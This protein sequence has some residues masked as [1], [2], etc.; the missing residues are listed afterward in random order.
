M[1]QDDILDALLTLVPRLGWTRAALAQAA[2]D[3]ALAENAFPRGPRDAIAHWS[4]RCDA[5][6][7][8]V[9]LDGL[10]TPGRIRALI[11]ARLQMAAPHKEALRQA[12]ALLA[13]P[14]NAPLAAALTAETV[15]AM[16]YA[17][18]DTSADFSWYTRRATLAA[19]YGA[20]LAFWLADRSE[21]MAPTLSFLDRRLE[22]LARLNRKPK[23]A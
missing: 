9:P 12:L 2:G 7:D 13:A 5:A 8:A 4:R 1:T 23:A 18:G 14:W 16:W 6:L 22:G 10:R 20:T 21:D 15:N 17:A 19:V 11:V 3:A